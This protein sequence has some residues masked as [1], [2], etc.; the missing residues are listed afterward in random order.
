MDILP[1]IYVTRHPE[2]SRIK[3]YYFQERLSLR[4][5]TGPGSFSP[6]TFLQTSERFF[7]VIE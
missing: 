6:P 1:D 7:G 3:L 5:K 4:Y 2:N